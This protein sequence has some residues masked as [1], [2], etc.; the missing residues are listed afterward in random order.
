MKP[1]TCAMKR[2]ATSGQQIGLSILI[3]ILL[4]GWGIKAF[5]SPKGFRGSNDLEDKVFVQIEGEVKTPGVYG[6][7]Q[8]PALGA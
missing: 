4:A 5:I 1:L 3:L 2:E 6:F 7:D 8:P